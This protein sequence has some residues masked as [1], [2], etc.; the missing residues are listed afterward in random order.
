MSRRAAASLLV[1]ALAACAPRE[2]PPPSA[3][4]AVALPVP[5]PPPAPPAPPVVAEPPP[6]APPPPAPPPRV[7]KIRFD[8]VYQ[9]EEV[10][11]G[12]P[13][14]YYLRFLANGSVVTASVNVAD[15]SPAKVHGWLGAPG[16]RGR[17][18]GRVTV[19]GDRV[20]F[21][22]SSPDGKVDY[23]ATLDGD[24]M[25]VKFTSHINGA[26]FEHTFR[27]VPVEGR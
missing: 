18:T 25:Q 26:R 4:P 13:Y 27:F 5:P 8:G 6:P 19:N 12:K 10:K 1:A 17:R 7:A 14:H 21:T 23:D 11:K 2:A 15:G 9:S 16:G 3:P 22:T 20:F 24:R